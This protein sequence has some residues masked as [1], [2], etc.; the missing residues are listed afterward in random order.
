MWK[1][2]EWRE[3]PLAMLSYFVAP[4]TVTASTTETALLWSPA[5]VS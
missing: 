2:V 3:N 1:D 4:A 5:E